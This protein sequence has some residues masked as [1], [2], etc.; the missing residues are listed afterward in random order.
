MAKGYSKTP[1]PYPLSDRK[2]PVFRALCPGGVIINVPLPGLEEQGV[3]ILKLKEC[4]GSDANWIAAM[5]G[6]A[7]DMQI[8]KDYM[9]ALGCGGP[10]APTSACEAL[11]DILDNLR[12]DYN[13]AITNRLLDCVGQQVAR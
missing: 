9:E 1:S 12:S 7:R 3:D 2:S 10:N 8:I 13:D 4:L 11:S 5:C 6:M